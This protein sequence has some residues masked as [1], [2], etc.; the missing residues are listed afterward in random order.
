MLGFKTV[1]RGAEPCCFLPMC[2]GSFLQIT[3]LN[4]NRRIYGGS[5]STTDVL[6]KKC[7]PNATA[8]TLR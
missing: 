3:D 6:P 1:P 8:E 2:Y 4:K 5:D 7:S